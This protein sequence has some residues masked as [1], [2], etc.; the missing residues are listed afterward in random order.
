MTMATPKATVKK[1]QAAKKADKPARERPEPELLLPSG[2]NDDLIPVD[3]L[4]RYNT[5]VEVYLQTL[6]CAAA[7]KAAGWVGKNEASQKAIGGQLLRN[8]YIRTRIE[9]QY[10]S[11]IVKTGA[12]VERVWEELTHI[13]F[14][15]PAEA[16]DESGNPKAIPEI[17]EHVRRCIT[18]RKKV[19]K[20]FGE[21]GSSEEEELKFAGK[22]AALDMLVRLHRMADNDKYVLIGGEEFLQAMEEG[23]ARASNRK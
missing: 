15:D 3:V 18:C 20:Q 8:P 14:L 22:Q 5:F 19:V 17:P 21:D 10:Q 2:V 11:I 4:M 13:A 6:D 23:R 1:K 16:F 12:T 7:A 9:R